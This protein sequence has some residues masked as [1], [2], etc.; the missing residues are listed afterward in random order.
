MSEPLEG[1]WIRVPPGYLLTTFEYDTDD[2]IVWPEHAHEE[3]ELLWSAGGMA[4][5][6]ADGRV[7][8]IPPALAVWVPSRIVH[9]ASAERGA[10]VRATYFTPGGPNTVAMPGV[11]T[12]VAM[13]E[14]LRV[15]LDHNLLGSLA[16]D[17]RLR[18]QRVILDLLMPAPR[19]SFDLVMPRSTHLHMVAS[20][21]LTDPADKRT[22]ADWGYECGM[23]GRTL[24][25]QF[26][27]E[28]GITFTQW[29]I[30]ARMQ[31]AIRELTHGRSIVSVARRV[32][33]RNPSTFIDH[34]RSLTGQT[35][36][37]Y[38]RGSRG[39]KPNAG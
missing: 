38:V 22:T 3:H 35:P 28:T 18:L 34:F 17:A 19:E 39:E 14:P 8:A 12:G 27:A 30:L 13:T 26:E 11:V 23:H 2:P 31:L 16:D 37:E 1:D 9:R 20:A 7:W 33:Y 21:I 29:R 4:R 32:G 24:A 6:E 10:R 5:L 15:L 36:A 25:R